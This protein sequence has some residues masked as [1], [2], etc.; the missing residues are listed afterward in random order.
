VYTFPTVG[1]TTTLGEMVVIGSHVY[2]SADDPL[3]VSVALFPGQ[4]IV[5]ELTMVTVGPGSTETV[6]RAWFVQVPLD[7]W[8]VKTVVANAVRVWK[9]P[10]AP[11]GSQVNEEAPPAAAVTLPPLQINVE[12]TGVMVSEGAMLIVIVCEAVLEQPVVSV[13][14]TE[15]VVVAVCV[16]VME[17]LF[18]PVFSQV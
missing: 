17:G 18:D 8:I 7:P 14:M 5:G 3:A 16:T 13:P 2:E 12:V 11:P 10:C 1:V 6:I 9:K 15:Y 4:T